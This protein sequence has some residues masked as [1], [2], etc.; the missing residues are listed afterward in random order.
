M[1]QENYFIY[2]LTKVNRRT[3]HV[4]IKQNIYHN[5]VPV[6]HFN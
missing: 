3:Q 2:C 4:E 1:K 6:V 5:L